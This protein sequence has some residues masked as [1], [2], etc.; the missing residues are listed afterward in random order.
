LFVVVE[1]RGR[2]RIGDVEVVAEPGDVVFVPAET[3]HSFHSTGEVPLRHVGVFPSSHV[4]T[5]LNKQ[6]PT[7]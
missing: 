5:E 6:P 4:E 2:Y 7:K 1:G 3:W